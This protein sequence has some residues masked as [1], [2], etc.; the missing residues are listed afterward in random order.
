MPGQDLS[1]FDAAHLDVLKEIGNI[2]AGNAATAL[3]RMLSL[4]IPMETPKVK[5]LA[6]SEADRALGGPETPA[7][8]VLAELSGEIGGMM[9]F[10]LD[11]RFAGLLLRRMLGKTRADLRNMTELERSVFSEIGNVM[12]GSYMRAV[13]SLS[14]LSIRMSVPAVTCD[15]VGSL[16]T[17]PAAEMGKVSDRIL[18]IEGSFAGS[19]FS[20]GGCPGKVNLMLV[21]RV[22]SL[23]KLLDSLGI[24]P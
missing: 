24:L 9:M 4:R 22:E 23:K 10:L 12:I 2:G 20:I 16:L 14:G 5:I 1:G 7:V 18:L 21:P 19:G 11:I 13:S 17:V 6:I 15:M 3:S 8:A